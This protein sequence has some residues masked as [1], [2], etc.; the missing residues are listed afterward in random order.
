MSK[1]NERNS[2]HKAKKTLNFFAEMN[3]SSNTYDLMKYSQ[4]L[5][6]TEMIPLK[7]SMTFDPPQ[8]AL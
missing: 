1:K 3:N 8:L 2:K 4:N 7:W 6:H 5:I